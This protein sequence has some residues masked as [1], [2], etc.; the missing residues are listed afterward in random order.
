MDILQGKDKL[1]QARE[2]L[3]GDFLAK[4]SKP[5]RERAQVDA[6]GGRIRCE[7]ADEQAADG[8]QEILEE[9]PG[10]GETSS[11]VQA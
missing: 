6:R 9:K 4:S 5:I 7:L 10:A 3:R 8:L 11:G 2:S 1:Q